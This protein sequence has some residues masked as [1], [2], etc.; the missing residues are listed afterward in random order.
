MLPLSVYKASCG[1]ARFILESYDLAMTGHGAPSLTRPENAT[2]TTHRPIH[3]S[4]SVCLSTCAAIFLSPPPLCGLDSH[5]S[6]HQV[7]VSG[8]TSWQASLLHNNS[9]RANI[10]EWVDRQDIHLHVYRQPVSQ[11]R[12]PSASTHP[13]QHVISLA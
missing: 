13:N 12:H 5:S 10:D 1:R 4:T 2:T 7:P 9:T 8:R 3:L 6:H 11:P